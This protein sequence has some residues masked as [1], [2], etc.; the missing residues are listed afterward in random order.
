MNDQNTEGIKGW[1]LVYLIGSVPLLMMY[2]MGL[3]GW[4]F[5]YPLV[6]MVGIFGV[7]AIPLVLII[8]KSHRAP[9]WNIALLWILVA[10]MTLRAVSI[11]LVEP[12]IFEGRPMSRA[13]LPGVL[14]P[15]SVIVGI[16]IAWAATWTTYFRKSLRVRNTFA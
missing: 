9:R 8:M 14:R 13:E 4:L 11:I 10:M 15:L 1:L 6:L 7:L 3:S 16:A 12:L 2:S 5:E